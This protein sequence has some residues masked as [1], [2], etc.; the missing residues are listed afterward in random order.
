M[1][2]EKKAGKMY[3]GIE[4]ILRLFC[5]AFSF[6]PGLIQRYVLVK[7]ILQTNFTSC[8]SVFSVSSVNFEQLKS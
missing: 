6:S 7:H 3:N 5:S 2:G 8:S 4:V 1:F